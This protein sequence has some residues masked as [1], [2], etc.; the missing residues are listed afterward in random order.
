MTNGDVLNA[1][2]AA[3]YIP[4]Q[5]WDAHRS[6]PCHRVSLWAYYANLAYQVMLQRWKNRLVKRRE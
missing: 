1:V 2:H 4:L 3:G 6:M 5:P